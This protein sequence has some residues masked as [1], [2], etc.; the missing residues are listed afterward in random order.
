MSKRPP[1][2][3][4]DCIVTFLDLLGFS[5]LVDAGAD[6]K[7]IARI[8]DELEEATRLDPEVG[9]AW[10]ESRIALSDSVI[11]VAEVTPPG[12]PIGIDFRMLLLGLV[13]AQAELVYRGIVLR[14]AI[15]R[16]DA[17]IDD[18]STHD[19]DARIFGP[20]YQAAYKAE[21]R[22]E[23][24]RIVIAE[25]LIEAIKRGEIGYALEQQEQFQKDLDEL[26]VYDSEHKIY[27]L[28]YLYMAHREV[29]PPGV[30]CDYLAAHRDLIQQR[31]TEHAKRHKVLRKYVWLAEY[32]NETL[33][34]FSPQ[35]FFDCCQV[36]LDSLR[37]VAVP[38]MPP[39]QEACR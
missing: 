9:K 28:D 22:E 37:I 36:D 30:Y 6:A 24:P 1:A 12:N 29:D 31:L 14:G 34:K 27:S 16:G 23:F 11:H 10:G 13:H 21:A 26:L 20:G 35:R 18:A 17:F 33:K 7:E 39:K 4:T 38:P 3:Y 8:L 15:T 19:G 5:Q 32:H 25:D 2:A